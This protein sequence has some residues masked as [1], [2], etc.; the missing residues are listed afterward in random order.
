MD[1]RRHHSRYDMIMSLMT[2]LH[3]VNPTELRRELVVMCKALAIPGGR[4][5]ILFMPSA[6]TDLWQ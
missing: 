1:I 5:Y 4:D 2:V 3:I 6:P